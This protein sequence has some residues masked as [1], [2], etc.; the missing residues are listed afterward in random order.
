[1]ST[2]HTLR[3]PGVAILFDAA[4]PP[5][6]GHTTWNQIARFG[7]FRGHPQGA[8]AFTP[9][10]FAEL[11]VNF[12]ATLNGRVPVDY[13]HT[14][15]VLP[16]NAA[17]EG[18]PAV[19]WVVA[20]DDRGPEG[21]WAAFEWV[22]PQAVE[23]VRA[24]R[25]LFL[26][27]AVHFDA[28]HRESGEKIGARLTSVAL[29]NHPFLDGLAPLT[30]SEPTA[31]TLGLAP[32]A[33][34]IPAGIASRKEPPPMDPEEKKI[35]DAKAEADAKKMSDDAGKYRAMST[36]LAALAPGL[37]MDPEATEDALLDR[38]AEIVAE[39]QKAQQ[40]EAATMA[41]AVC[42][43]GRV[44]KEGR[45]DLIAM[46]LS[47]RAKFLRM[48][49][50][51]ADKPAEKP[52]D[53]T[54]DAKALLTGRVVDQRQHPAPVAE[55][56]DTDHMAEAREADALAQKLLREKKAGDYATAIIMAS[57]EVRAK[58]TDAALARLVPT[59]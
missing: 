36:K 22:D 34:H 13:E 59:A 45:A 47:D 18:V 58:R 51:Q 46:C 57:R 20:L 52:A 24:K 40:A 50:A 2:P 53:L 39:M 56:D 37:G 31:H 3:A 49:P 5:A 21:L 41:D 35:A 19:A 23:Y 8:F 15:E 16:D 10:V 33:V 26:S 43:S 12:S 25:Y 55:S 6:V 42:A 48:F 29:T 14:S 11:V 7:E 4:T 38:L 28:T 9:E 1:M 54:P 27:P 32:D 17:Q 44:S 30:A